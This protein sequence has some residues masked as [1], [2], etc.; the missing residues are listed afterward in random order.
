MRTNIDIDDDLMA[1]AMEAGGFKSKREAVEEGLRL[2]AR[3]KAY[4]AILAARGSLQWD[5][6]DE[7]WAAYRQSQQAHKV[8]QPVAAYKPVRKAARSPALTTR[9]PK[10]RSA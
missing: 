8:A 2:I 1:R 7:G 4:A 3:R 9:R 5:D 10:P 6:S